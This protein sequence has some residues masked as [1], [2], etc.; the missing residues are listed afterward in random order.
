MP[1]HSPP[2]LVWLL[3]LLPF[4]GLLWVPLYNFRSPE[5]WGAQ[6]SC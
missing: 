2:R 4:V 6:P 3:L 5:L 1:E